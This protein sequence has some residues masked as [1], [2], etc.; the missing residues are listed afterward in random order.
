MLN[1]LMHFNFPAMFNQRHRYSFIFL[2]SICTYISTVLCDVYHFFNIN[3]EWYYALG[4]IATITWGSWEVN[5]LLESFFIRR[6]SVHKNKIRVLA[7][8]LFSGS[9]FTTLVAF[10][11]VTLVSMILHNYT[12][13][14]TLVPLKLNIIY[15]WL[16]NLLFHLLNAVFLYI[17]EYKTKWME[18]E[19]L[20]RMSAQAE[21][22]I[23]K[24][25]INPH[26]L[27]NNL[28]V[29]STLIMQNNSEANHFI[30]AFS[31]VYRYILNNHEKELVELKTEL[32]FLEPYIFLLKT[33]FTEG[34][35][36]NLD[37]PEN[38]GRFQ[39]IPAA[40]QMLIENAIKHN[41]V[42]RNKPLYI[43]V[44]INDNNKIVISNNLQAKQT[45]ENSTGIGLLNIIKRYEAVSKQDVAIKNDAKNFSVSLPL[46]NIN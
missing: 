20:K 23:V 21:L 39:I 37:I 42:S 26:F 30:E 34:L 7:F 10:T 9:F 41:V 44:H 14:E 17:N 29:L 13:S 24:N 28:N 1:P 2:L 12:F 33:R 36:I 31:K 3:I 16:V 8:F 27:F 43:D 5:R 22:Q 46:I 32:H 15:A 19:E 45:V 25:Q 6:F 11:T 35:N 18:A 38:F 40:L 4:T